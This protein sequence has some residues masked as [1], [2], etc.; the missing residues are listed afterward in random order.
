[1]PQQIS[2]PFLDLDTG[3]D[4]SFGFLHLQKY[5]MINSIK[6]LNIISFIMCPKT[7]FFEAEALD[8]SITLCFLSTVPLMSLK[9]KLAVH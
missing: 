1:M 7:F 8:I 5:V 4:E 3:K 9:A 6:Q 2:E